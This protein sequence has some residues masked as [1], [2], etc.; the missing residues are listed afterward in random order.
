[1]DAYYRWTC[2]ESGID[3]DGGV[4][5]VTVDKKENENMIDYGLKFDCQDETFD[6][7]F[8]DRLDYIIKT[9]PETYYDSMGQQLVWWETMIEVYEIVSISATLELNYS[10]DFDDTGL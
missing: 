2:D 10:Q 4:C 5:S 9:Q 7:I 6:R 8:E 1:M 3:C